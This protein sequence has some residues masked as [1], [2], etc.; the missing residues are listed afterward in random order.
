VRAV[1]DLRPEGPRQQ[2]SRVV[3]RRISALAE[4][5]LARPLRPLPPGTEVTCGSTSKKHPADCVAYGD[6]VQFPGR[7]SVQACILGERWDPRGAYQILA[8]SLWGQARCDSSPSV[9]PHAAQHA[10]ATAG[11]AAWRGL[12]PRSWVSSARGTSLQCE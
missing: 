3:G 4:A 12:R 8:S 7:W 11:Y 9:A 10:F 1:L 2:N 5:G 6:S